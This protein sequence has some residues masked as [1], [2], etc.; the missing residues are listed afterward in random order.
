[1]HARNVIDEGDGVVLSALF[2]L[3]S[4]LGTRQVTSPPLFKHF[5]VISILNMT[6]MRGAGRRATGPWNLKRMARFR[7]TSGSA[8]V[9]E[10]FLARS[11]AS[12]TRD[13]YVRGSSRAASRHTGGGRPMWGRSTARYEPTQTRA[14]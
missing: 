3:V 13:G 7:R 4:H 9:R 6:K 1:M 12:S 14:L 10:S 11:I 5:P 8:Q 2:H